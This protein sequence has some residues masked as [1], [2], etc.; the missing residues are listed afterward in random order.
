[1]NAPTMLSQQI[2]KDACSI[3]VSDADDPVLIAHVSN[4]KL[5]AAEQSSRSEGYPFSKTKPA[6]TDRAA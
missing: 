4:I 5:S 6:K 3:L 2:Y 1:M